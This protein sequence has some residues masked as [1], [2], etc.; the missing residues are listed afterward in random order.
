MA[1]KKTSTSAAL[2]MNQ[3]AI[4][5]LVTDSVVTALEPQAATMTNTNN[6]NRNTRQR[7]TLVARK[8]SYKEF[9][10]CQPFNF[11]DLKQGGSSDQELQKQRASHWKQSAT[12][13]SNL[14]CLWREMELQKSVPK[15]KQRSTRD[16]LAEGQERSPR[17]ERSYRIIYDEK[18]VHNPIDGETLIIRGDRSKTRL[19]LISCTKVK[20]YISKGYQVF[21]A[22]VMEKKLDKKTIGRYSSSQGATPVARAPYRLA[23]S[24]MQ[25]LSDQLQVLADRGSS[26]YSKI[27]LRSGYHQLRVRD[28]DIPKTAFRMSQGIHVDPT[29]IEAVKNWASP[30]TPTEVCQFLGLVGYYQKFIEDFSKIAKSLTELTKKQEVYLGRKP[31]INFPT[32]KTKVVKL[33]I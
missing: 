4:R 8:C 6:T 18:V 11:K 22:Q 9:M 25:E 19:S 27:D 13:V 5:K 20:R 31:R 29:K 26:V 7:K 32:A 33:Q 14:S 17:S 2:A 10:S 21:I 23:P 28:K 3:A 30:T 24:Q 15:S 16:I 12:S 1:P